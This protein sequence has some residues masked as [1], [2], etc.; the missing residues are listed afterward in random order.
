MGYAHGNARMGDRY[1]RVDDLGVARE[2]CEIAGDVGGVAGREKGSHCDGGAVALGQA[3]ALMRSSETGK[4]FVRRILNQLGL[5]PLKAGGDTGTGVMVGGKH[6]RGR[7]RLGREFHEDLA[8]WRKVM[9]M[10]TGPDGIV[11]LE[12]PLLCSFLQAPSRTLVSDA[13]G[14]GMGRFCLESGQWWRIDFTD[15]IRARLRNRVFYRDDLSMNVFEVL[16][17]VVTAWA[18][19]VQAGVKPEYPEQSILTRGDNMSVGKK[20]N[21]GRVR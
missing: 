21:P 1:C 13:S 11:K 7:V 3:A 4:V 16:G 10:A 12:A 17:M 2:G 18:L 20:I 6:R 9:A 5:P 19:T 15:D 8:F 14:D